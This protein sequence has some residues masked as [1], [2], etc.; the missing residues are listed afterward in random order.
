MLQT[1]RTPDLTISLRDILGI[2]VPM[3][4]HCDGGRDWLIIDVEPY[5]SPINYKGQY[6]YRSGNTKQELKGADFCCA[7][8]RHWDAVPVPYVGILRR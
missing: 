7:Q 3:N 6:H 2:V 1:S 4:L 8:G 5:P